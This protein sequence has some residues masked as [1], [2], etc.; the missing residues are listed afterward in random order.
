MPE[1]PDEHTP[2]VRAW[3]R[4]SSDVHA[5]LAV[6][7]VADLSERLRRLSS[8]LQTR[9]DDLLASVVD[10]YQPT[11]ADLSEVLTTVERSS[12]RQERTDQ[13]GA[14]LAAALRS[15]HPVVGGLN[16]QDAVDV[17]RRRQ[18]RLA[19]RLGAPGASSRARP[20]VPAQPAPQEPS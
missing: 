16:P 19:E 13:E 6:E 17:Q 3:A 11:L 15:R 4:R 1:V 10:D 2:A 9:G 7:R 12:H 18:M 14:A 8:A 5:G 20:E